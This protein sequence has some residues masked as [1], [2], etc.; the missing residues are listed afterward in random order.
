MKILIDISHPAHVH[1]FKNFMGRMEDKGHEILVAAKDKDVAL[2]LLD[3]YG[4]PYNMVGK[5]R[6][7]N[8]EKMV[9]MFNISHRIYGL[10]RD[11]RPDILTGFGGLNAAHASVFLRKPCIVFSDS[12]VVNLTHR[13]IIPFVDAICTPSSFTNRKLTKKQVIFN[14][15]K[16][17]AYLHP[18]NFK[19]D[20]SVR[21]ELG[22]GEN[23]KYVV[24]RFVAWQASHDTGQHG[25]NILMK[26][27]LITALEEY[28]Q[29]FITSE[30][31]L[32]AQFEKYRVRIAPDRM[33]DLLYYASLLVGD[34][35]TM[36]TEAAV[37]G[38]PAVRCNSFV[39]HND[40]GNFIEL[41]NKYD[42]IY[43]F[44]E[45]D[46]AIRKAV[47][48]IQQPDLKEQWAKKRER[49]LDDK[50]DV[51]QFMVDFIEGYPESFYRY[52]EANGNRL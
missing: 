39:G 50:I 18:S 33:H 41:E 44:R 34:S 11:F 46:K 22:L 25:L 23:D 20:P 32:P 19:P 31:P 45:P 24:M 28:A 30:G 12:E 7:N 3:R 9:D 13:L 42:L 5:Y 43:S 35:Q 6:K 2:Q 21:D 49:L 40:M 15:Y 52:K 4:L 38:T 29:V 17:L 48:L 51:T 14:G 8:L 1:F 26:R 16:E 27:H 47:E 36:T 37:L 10:A